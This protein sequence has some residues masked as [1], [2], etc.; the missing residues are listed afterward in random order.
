MGEFKNTMFAFLLVSLVILGSYNFVLS[1]TARSGSGLVPTNLSSISLITRVESQVNIYEQQAR[2]STVSGDILNIAYTLVTGVI[3]VLRL[4]FEATVGLWAALIND[5][6][7]L[8]GIPAFIV[9]IFTAMA[10][11]YML[12]ALFSAVNKWNL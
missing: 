10:A 9:S 1:L 11:I 4:M 8:I 12:F 5:V 7:A 6:A 3:T 2:T